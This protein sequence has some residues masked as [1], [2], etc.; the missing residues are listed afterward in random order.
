MLIVTLTIS[1]RL[2]I[3]VPGVAL[4]VTDLAVTIWELITLIVLV[5]IAVTFTLIALPDTSISI[6]LIAVS[7]VHPLIAVAFWTILTLA[8]IRITVPTVSL[9]VTVS[10]QII[11]VASATVLAAITAVADSLIILAAIAI[12]VT[13]AAEFHIATS[14][15]ES[16][17]CINL[18]A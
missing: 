10:S 13:A 6:P 1:G 4:W 2:G 5:G 3:L 15:S 17:Q 12:T 11:S 9:D 18:L 14:S 8:L 16:T 7:P